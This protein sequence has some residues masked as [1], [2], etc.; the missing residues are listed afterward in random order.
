MSDSDGEGSKLW[1]ENELIRKSGKECGRVT[2][3]ET[4][5]I[6]LFILVFLIQKYE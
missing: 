4:R 5:K 2:E 6:I 3:R 1:Y